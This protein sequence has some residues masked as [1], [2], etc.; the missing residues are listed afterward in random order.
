MNERELGNTLEG[1]LQ[2]ITV[3]PLAEQAVIEV[4][5]S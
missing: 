5:F 1:L 4:A 3:H 2:D